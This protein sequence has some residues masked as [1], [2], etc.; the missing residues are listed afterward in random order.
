MISLDN[1]ISER[2]RLVGPLLLIGLLILRLPY[3]IGVSAYFGFDKSLPVLALTIFK[4]G[5]FLL[6]ALLIWWERKRLREF[7]ITRGVL[8]IIIWGPILFGLISIILV[9]G[10]N[11]SLGQVPLIQ[12]LIAFWLFWIIKR[13]PYMIQQHDNKKHIWILI[14]VV[15]GICIGLIFGY[16]NGLQ[17][18]IGVIIGK[19][20]SL[21]TAAS[22]LLSAQSWLT[23]FPVFMAQ[24]SNAA[25]L[26]EPL[27][28]GFLW[29]YLRLQGWN[30]KWILLLQA[31]LFWVGHIYYLGVA[32]YSFWII[33]PLSGL[34]LGF[35]AWRSRSIATSMTTHG[36]FNAIGDFIAHH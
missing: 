7:H 17:G 24:L 1:L 25:T 35:L 19:H 30:E 23:I 16:L 11:A 10:G 6:T 29:G 26:E 14:A 22:L 15:V 8:V 21:A 27:F 36:L 5:T 32:P 3:L 28:R 33:I 34:V 12:M 13:N 31:L 2:R 18:A 20:R 9:F 4:N